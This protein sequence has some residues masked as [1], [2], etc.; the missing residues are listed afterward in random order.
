VSSLS[1]G[2]DTVI[3]AASFQIHVSAA[4]SP[5]QRW[6]FRIL[7]A[8]I[9]ALFLL[10]SELVHLSHGRIIYISVWS[11]VQLATLYAVSEKR[12]ERYLGLAFGLPT[13]AGTWAAHF[14]PQPAHDVVELV[15][16]GFGAAFFMLVA[17]MVMS[18][19][20]THE[21]TTDNVV[22]AICAYLQLGI[23]VSLIYL[24]VESLQPGSFQATG[25]LAEEM[26]D[27]VGRRSVLAYFSFVTLTTSGYG[28]ITPATPLTRALAVLEAVTGQF[29]LAILVAGLIGLKVGKPQRSVRSASGGSSPEG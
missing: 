5:Y 29:Y 24:I 18:H 22:G 27:P 20:V 19:L 25:A 26:A 9:L 28:D 3:E 8:A 2:N 1:L 13:L 4:M 21:V 6:K 12:K 11:L 16:F 23:G 7:L 15:G 17:V 14:L 10:Q